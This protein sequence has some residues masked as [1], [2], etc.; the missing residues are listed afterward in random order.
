MGP[1][2][3]RFTFGPFQLD[4]RE[5]RLLRGGEAV[6]LTLKAFELLRVLV[7]NRGHLLTKEELLRR[8]WPDA[9]VEENNLTVTMSALRKALD[10]GPT[11]RQY[12]ETVPRRGYRFV[13]DLAAPADEPAA[14]T[15]SLAHSTCWPCVMLQGVVSP[16][17]DTTP[18]IGLWIAASSSPMARM[19]ARCGVRSRP[20]RVMDERRRISIFLCHRPRKRAIQ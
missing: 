20:S 16:F 15:P 6:P 7:E 5:Q 3:T 13:A 12:I 14:S 19:K 8:V 11:D 1:G 18:I 9:V 17:I 4:L 2:T 10:E